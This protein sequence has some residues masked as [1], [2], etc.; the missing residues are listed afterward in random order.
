MAATSAGVSPGA[1]VSGLALAGGLIAMVIV[2]LLYP[3][4]ALVSPVDHNQFP[5]AVA[6]MTEN[7]G[8]THVLSMLTIVAMFTAAFGLLYLFRLQDDH[9]SLGRLFLRFGLAT[10]L[11]GWGVFIVA[12][13]MTHMV[14]HVARNGV[15]GGPSEA[16]LASLALAVYTVVAGVQFAFATIFPFASFFTGLGLAA[17]LGGRDIYSGAAYGLT[18]VGVAGVFNVLFAQHLHN[19]DISLFAMFNAVILMI[20]AVFLVTIGV[21]MYRGRRGLVSEGASG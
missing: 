12:N 19:V 7:D 21:G 3:G 6:V 9:A 13:G 8:L 20:G 2:S 16:E 4:G 11:F 18:V 17:R 1:K 15:G 10:T 5:D 14:V